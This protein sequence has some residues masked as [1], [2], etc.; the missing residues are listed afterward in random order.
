MRRFPLVVAPLALLTMTAAGAGKPDYKP[1]AEVSEGYTKVVST[2]DG[3]KP[4][5]GLYI[6]KK[7]NQLLAELPQG[8]K[9]Q[10]HLFAVTQASGG[11]FAGLQGPMIYAYWRQYDKRL[12]L[13]A[14][15]LDTRSKGEAESK[16]SV[17]RLFTDTVLVDVP[18]LTMGPSGQPV[19]DFDGLLVNKGGALMR[20][21]GGTSNANLATIVKAK[22]F[23]Q[24]VEVAIEAPARG[25]K[26]TTYHFSISKLPDNT[27]Y[28]PRAA[29]ERVGYF[30]TVYRDL[31]QYDQ[32]KKWVRYIDRWHLEKRDPKLKLSPPKEPIVFHIEHTVPVRY[33]RYIRNG[34]LYWNEAFREIGIDEA[35][36]VRF[37]DKATGAHMEKDPEDVRYNF[38]RWLNNDISTA[39]GPHRAHPLTGQILDA[40]VVLTDGWIRAYWGWF[41]EQAP[42]LAVEGFSAETLR[43][44]DENP[45]WDPRVLLSSPGEATRRA[46]IMAEID[47]AAMT[48]DTALPLNPDL[49]EIAGW[50]DDPSHQ[51]LAA[52]GLAFDM[53]FG[54]M[55]LESL[56]LLEAGGYDAAE[57]D[58]LDGIPEWFVGPLLAELVAHEVGHTIGLRHNFKASGI[59]TMEQI[60]SAEWKGK[61]PLAGS[62]MDY[63]PPNFNLETGEEQGDFT[64]IGVG[65]YDK[66]AIA[67]GYTFDDPA[68]VLERVAEPELAYLTDD[69][70]TGPDPFARRYDFS[71]NPLTYAKNQMRIVDQHRERIL[72][73]FVK[74]GESWSNARRGYQTTLSMQM[75]M[76]SMMSNWIGGAHVN[77][78]RKGDPDG[79]TPIEVTDPDRQRAA[80]QW[81]ID[82]SF[83]DEAFDL[84]PELILH[85]TVDKWSDQSPGDRSDPTWPVHSRVMGVQASVLTMIMNPTTLTRVYD[86]ELRTPSSEDALTVPELMTTVFDAVY[87]EL[88]SDLDGHTFTDREPMISSLRRNLQSAMADRLIGLATDSGRMPQPV[89]TVAAW[90]LRRLGEKLD[91]V[92]EKSDTGQIDQYTLAH[93]ADLQDRVQKAMNRL[94][95]ESM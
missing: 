73:K 58:L 68:K 47:A 42:E 44:L 26:L 69:D 93:L 65:P 76:L 64:M 3:A 39:I 4:F 38:I 23:P 95:V 46:E 82:H 66:W 62:V 31:G 34:V 20:G 72:E 9:T 78:D 80:L 84:T 24:N 75:R 25:G 86:N 28:K 22:A 50:M 37:Q 8:W 45:G 18:I 88:D 10:R 32:K 1:F 54:R 52:H 81:V 14:P 74:D 90:H 55:N 48:S 67:Y 7:K 63:L 87:T 70:T 19:I 11:T 30:T 91:P 33:R 59:Y 17:K 92:I 6:D 85:M 77:R 13:I 29:D 27:G 21:R 12:A 51:C 35:I 94:Y 15:E 2:A 79:R 56:G 40:D 61:K 57:G 5:Y 60:N 41:N 53:A 49:A 43:W 16:S 89:R 36:Q 83:H 71:A